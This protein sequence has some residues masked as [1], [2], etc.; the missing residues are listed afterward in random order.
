LT[1]SASSVASGGTVTLTWSSQNATSCTASGGSGWTGSQ[2]TSGTLA[3]VVTAT[4]TLTLTCTGAGG[5]AAQSI[6]VTATAAASSGG[7]GG[8]MEEPWILALLGLWALSVRSRFV[9]SRLRL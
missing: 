4:E 2:A 1:S 6:T 3:V 5:S 7:G 8:A 9:R